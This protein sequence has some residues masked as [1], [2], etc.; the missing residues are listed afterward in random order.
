MKSIKTIFY[1]LLFAAVLAVPMTSCK[2]YLDKAPDSDISDQDVYGDFTS[3]QGFV[4]Q[5]YKCIADP[6]KCGAW[7]NYSFADENLGPGQYAFDLGNYWNSSTYFYGTTPNPNDN[8][9]RNRRI[10]EWAW[11]AIRVA[12][13]AIANLEPAEGAESVFQG[14]DEEKNLLL[15]QALFF[16]GWFYFEICR[17]WGGMPYIIHPIGASENMT[18]EEYNRLNF[19]DTAL[20][21]AADFDR[22]AQLLPEDWDDT[23]AGQ[24]TSGHNHQRVNKYFALGYKGKALLYAASPMMQEEATGTSKTCY[25]F[26]GNLC[27]QAAETFGELISLCDQTGDYKLQP[28]ATYDY[29]FFRW[30]N[31]RPGGDE[32][33]MMPTIYENNRTRWSAMGQ[34][35]PADLGMNSGGPDVP[36]HNIVKNFYMANGLPI[37]DPDS[38]Y[39]PQHPWDNREFRFYN[40]IIYYGVRISTIPNLEFANGLETGGFRRTMSKPTPT[41]YYQ[42]KFNGMGADYNTSSVEGLQAF[43][44]FLRLGDIYLMYAEAVNFM[45]GGGPSAKASSCSLTAIDAVNA[46]RN[47]VEL[48]DLTA[49]YTADKQVFFDDLIQERAAEL[50]MEGARFCDLRRWNLNYD[51]KY[52]DKTALDYDLDADGNPCNFSERVV[53]TRTAAKKHNW[54]PIQVKYTKIYQGFAQNPGW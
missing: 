23:T 49:K 40:N 36:T 12:N 51:P 41:G 46:I 22:A 34:T 8:T 29:I 17:F 26:D 7:N 52:L 10:W 13:L 32:A 53:I 33:I 27:K 5:M 25:D 18:T 3:F 48:P 31:Q 4:E 1:S 16:R 30:N 37:D 54:L 38:G 11:Y 28:K 35:V 24:A 39:D 2:D 9:T 14:T 6:D 15:G 42:R 44:P 50:F 21:M 47:R 45:T 20:L 19:R 43:C